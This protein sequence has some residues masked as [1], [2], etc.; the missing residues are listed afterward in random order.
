MEPLP[1]PRYGHS[2]MQQK[3]NSRKKWGVGQI[4]NMSLLISLQCLTMELAGRRGA[5]VSGG[6]LT[7]SDVQ[8]L[9]FQTG[10]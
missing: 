4:I 5:L 10:K 9:D 3:I 8:F 2:V 1:K 6:A 7:G